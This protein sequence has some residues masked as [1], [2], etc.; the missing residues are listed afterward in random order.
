M[1]ILC[2]NLKGILGISVLIKKTVSLYHFLLFWSNI[3]NIY[4]VCILTFIYFC[5]YNNYAN[6]YRIF[7]TNSTCA[8]NKQHCKK[9]Y[10]NKTL[11]SV[12]INDSQV[13]NIIY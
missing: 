9:W 4:T 6:N 11:Y 2:N 3:T 13:N 12:E 7:L 8:A 10:T 1:K 5:E